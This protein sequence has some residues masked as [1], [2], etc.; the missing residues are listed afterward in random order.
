MRT[1]Y[2]F[3]PKKSRRRPYPRAPENLSYVQYCR[4]RGID[5]DPVDYDTVH[6]YIRWVLK[7]QELGET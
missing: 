3:T 2:F 6:D 4:S 1:V 7:V 5:P